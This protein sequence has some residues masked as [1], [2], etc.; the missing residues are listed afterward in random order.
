M[1]DAQLL[2]TLEAVADE[3]GVEIRREVLDGSRG[4]LVRLRGRPCI[5]VDRDL[6]LPERVDLMARS[7]AR[8]PLDGVFIPPVVREFLEVR[9]IPTP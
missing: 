3:L 8:L 5:L 2:Q 7:L 4:G 1:T 9:A 6:S